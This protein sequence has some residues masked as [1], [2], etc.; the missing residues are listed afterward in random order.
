[1]DDDE[2]WYE[3]FDKPT[4][5]PRQPERRL[6]PLITILLILLSVL[7]GGGSTVFAAVRNSSQDLVGFRVQLGIR[8]AAILEG[9]LRYNRKR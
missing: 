8:S 2:E 5:G 9:C 3:N 1:M 4:C 6:P 7:P